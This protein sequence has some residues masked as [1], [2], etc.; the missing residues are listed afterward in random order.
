MAEKFHKEIKKIKI[1]ELHLDNEKNPRLPTKLMGKSDETILEYMVIDANVLE[2]M[3]SIGEKGFFPG[4]P[5]LVVPS[6]KKGGHIVIEGN[7]R[8]SAVML[9]RNPALVTARK[10]SLA[11]VV[12]NATYK[13]D[14]LPALIYDKRE[15]ILDYLGY[16]HI[17]GVKPWDPLAKAR[18]LR[19][20]YEMSKIKNVD[21]RCAHLARTIGSGT[22]TDYVKK[23]LCGLSIYNT[24]EDTNYFNIKNLSEK[25]ISF[26]L[27]TTALGYPKL[28][29]Y[30]GLESSEEIEPKSLDL[31]H[32][33]DLSK[34]MFEKIDRKTLLG[35][36][37]NLNQLAD[38]VANEVALKELRSGASLEV[39]YYFSEGAKESVINGISEARKYLDLA[40]TYAKE[41]TLGEDEHAQLEEIKKTATAIKKQTT[42][43]PEDA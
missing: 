12:E 23:L 38:V 16:R 24:I 14:T 10:K 1:E 4:E 32:L 21:E 15:E 22:R 25:T 30:L 27:I 8:L 42:P 31:N 36:S 9:L 40:Y 43:S 20:L 19:Q 34:W 35:E 17:T 39:A 18:Y 11:Q 6:E 3:A 13:P 28:R 37:R 26:S 41:V 5:L 29:D 33:K 7:R 2:L